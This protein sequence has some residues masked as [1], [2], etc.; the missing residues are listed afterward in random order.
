MNEWGPA[1]I[2]AVAVI[3]LIQ[4][5]AFYYLMKGNDG[6]SKWPSSTE[7]TPGNSAMGSVSAA[8]HE[9]T[10]HE[11]GPREAI[12]HEESMTQCPHC[13]TPNQKDPMFT[14]CRNCGSEL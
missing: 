2:T 1:I 13:G 10:G 7:E 9:E 5:V 6:G 12:D 4:I 8:D 11:E 14:F 3:T